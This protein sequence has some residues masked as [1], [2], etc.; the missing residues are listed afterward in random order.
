MS[1][2]LD[3]PIV[4]VATGAQ[5]PKKPKLLLLT[6]LSLLFL[7]RY[8][9]M[10]SADLITKA[11]PL[12]H[13]TQS[14]RRLTTE[15]GAIPDQVLSQL[16]GATQELVPDELLM[17][18]VNQVLLENSKASIPAFVELARG[19]T[20]LSVAQ[21]KDATKS[22]N[23]LTQALAGGA[24]TPALEDDLG[25]DQSVRKQLEWV[26]TLDQSVR[27]AALEVMLL[28]DISDQNARLGAPMNTPIDSV[29]RLETAWTNMAAA[30][31][32]ATARMADHLKLLKPR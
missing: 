1:E 16:R 4:D 24:P 14:F 27:Q 3:A 32:V 19:V 13:I 25:L 7:A 11:G 9:G 5:P 30:A 2:E 22:M 20:N 6:L 26:N 23:L 17:K 12:G 28:K 15:A 8:A 31:S 21:G 10:H 29:R 18:E